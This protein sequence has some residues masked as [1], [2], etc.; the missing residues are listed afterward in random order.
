VLAGSHLPVSFTDDKLMNELINVKHNKFCH[1]N[2]LAT[3][4]HFHNKLIM[5]NKT[6]NINI[7]WPF[8]RYWIYKMY[9]CEYECE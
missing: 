1:H 6:V 3:N 9:L 4:Q 2:A 8:D 5:P 7:H